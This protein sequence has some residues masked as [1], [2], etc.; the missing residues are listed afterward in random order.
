M[1]IERV[2]VAAL[3]VSMSL[4]GCA[5]TV[6]EV[7]ATG[8]DRGVSRQSKLVIAHRGASGYLPEHTLA[9]KAMAYAQGADFIEQDLVMSKD[10]Q[11]IVLHDLYLDTVTGPGRTAAITSSISRWQRSAG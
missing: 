2:G 6:N 8:N 7:A 4:V 1:A 3:L 10:D 5:T 9:A 11:V